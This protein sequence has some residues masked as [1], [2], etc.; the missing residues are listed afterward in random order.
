[1]LAA[2]ARSALMLATNVTGHGALAHE[3]EPTADRKAGDVHLIEVERAIFLGPVVVVVW[4]LVPLVEQ[5]AVVFRLAADLAHFQETLRP[6]SAAD[7]IALVKQA[8]PRVDHVLADE[9]WRLRHRKEVLREA[10]LRAAEGADL[11]GTPPL[12]GDPLA[13]IVAIFQ[14]APP[15]GP[16]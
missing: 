2:R 15:Q 10:P 6:R 14:L 1:L 5:A 16:I 13:G 3:V 12:A 8:Q 4:M 9:M 7:A 11:A